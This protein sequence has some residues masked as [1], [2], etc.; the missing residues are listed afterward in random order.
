MNNIRL[1]LT[2]KISSLIDRLENIPAGWPML[3]FVAE[4]LI[5]AR[6]LLQQVLVSHFTPHSLFPLKVIYTHNWFWALLFSLIF[7]ISYITKSPAIKITRLLVC[8]LPIIF[9]PLLSLIFGMTQNFLIT[10]TWREILF[11]ISTFVAFHPNLGIFFTIEIVVFLSAIFSYFLLRTSIIKS[12]VGVLGVYTILS[13]FAIQGKSI[14]TTTRGVIAE[15]NFFIFLFFLLLVFIREFPAKTKALVFHLRPKRFVYLGAFGIIMAIGASYSEHFLPYN[16]SLGFL[17]FS[18]FLLHAALINDMWDIEI[19]T[20]SNPDRPYAQGILSRQEMNVLQYSILGIMGALIL[21]IYSPAVAIITLLNIGA[22]FLY[23]A[24][25][26]R[27]NIFSLIIVAFGESTAVLYGYFSQNPVQTTLPEN[28]SVLFTAFFFLFLFFLP[29]KDLK[30]FKGDSAEGVKNIMTLFGWRKGKAVTALSVFLGYVVFASLAGDP[31]LLGAS[32]FF[33]TCGALFVL[34]YEKVGEQISY[35]NFFLFIVVVFIIGVTVP[36][37]FSTEKVYDTGKK[38]EKRQSLEQTLAP[39]NI[40]ENGGALNNAISRAKDFYTT[41][42]L[43]RSL[44]A[45]EKGKVAVFFS[46]DGKTSEVAVDHVPTKGEK[47]KIFNKY[48]EYQLYTVIHFLMYF[49]DWGYSASD[50]LVE[51]GKQWLVSTFDAQEGRWVWSEQGCS[52]AKAIIALVRLGEKEKAKKAMEWALKSDLRIENGFTELQTDAVI[53]SFSKKVFTPL[54]TK[55]T[56]EKIEKNRLNREETAKF[57]YAMAA[58]D[59]T[60]TADFQKVKNALEQSYS[61]NIPLD[62]FVRTFSETVAVSWI[63]Y[64]YEEYH[65]PKDGLYDKARAFVIALAEKDL[66]DK[67]LINYSRGKIL[68]ALSLMRD[69]KAQSLKEGILK[70]ILD[71]QFPD[72]HWEP[73]GSKTNGQPDDSDESKV[74]NNGFLL[75]YKGGR[76]S[77]TKT[78]LEALV[79]F[80]NNALN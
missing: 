40:Q 36:A 59:M 9:I 26:F 51:R 12:C 25:R 29:L 27:K 69:E 5:S 49:Q 31:L 75:N 62:Y 63:V 15:A 28:I 39:K 48:V 17:L 73:N 37:R 58:L 19:D 46:N 50:P 16:F 72:G 56:T 67:T 53:H 64:A 35:V 78:I 6:A 77:T 60:D 52:H 30:D 14:L 54:Q 41:E 70:T 61:K 4:M 20:I 7:F 47:V 55:N 79:V 1:Q 10:G 18:L 76:G 42:Y 65:I 32:L 11:H 2:S 71:T 33:A 44:S 34:F 13:L 23:S 74:Y 24:A 68:M 22:S 57:L 45:V 3:F 80:R 43:S 66:S 8:G 21:I 38:T